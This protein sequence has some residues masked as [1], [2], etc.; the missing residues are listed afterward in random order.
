[1]KNMRLKRAYE[2]PS[3]DDGQ[4]VLVE[5]LWPRG[6]TKSRAKIDAWLK[7]VAPSHELRKW[8]NH[9]PAKWPEFKRRYLF[10]LRS[11][12][13]ELAELNKILKNGPLTLVYA[14][15]DEERNSARVLKELIER[16]GP[17]RTARSASDRR[18]RTNAGTHRT[19]R[20]TP[21]KG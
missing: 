8:Y 2:P 12:R 20:K 9:D 18:A 15:R 1:M 11:R 7:G 19:Q 4:R 17:R 13:E 10:E 6:L 5:R 3:P 21:K 16:R 14:A